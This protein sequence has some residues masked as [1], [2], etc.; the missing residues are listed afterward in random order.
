V[1]RTII[2][3]EHQNNRGVGGGVTHSSIHSLQIFFL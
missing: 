3:T 2:S 1:H